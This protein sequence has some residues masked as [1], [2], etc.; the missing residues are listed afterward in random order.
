MYQCRSFPATP[1][2]GRLAGAKCAT[3]GVPGRRAPTLTPT[4]FRGI[5]EVS[6]VD[7]DFMSV[8]AVIPARGGSKGIPR[9]NMR[10]LAGRPL[11]G[12]VIQACQQSKSVDRVVVSTDSEEIAVVARRLG[13]EV[14]LRDPK[15]AED[16]VTLDP[17]IH[18]AVT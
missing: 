13:A 7:N 6:R 8:L 10:P 4:T 1:S 9:K 11:L 17:V 16:V 5:I 14:I 3:L 15:L 18:D 2:R 12:W